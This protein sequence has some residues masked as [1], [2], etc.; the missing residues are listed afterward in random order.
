ML[1]VSTAMSSTVLSVKRHYPN[2]L[3]PSSLFF[4][5]VSALFIILFNFTTIGLALIYHF[6]VIMNR[7]TPKAESQFSNDARMNGIS[8]VL[9]L[10]KI[11]VPKFGTLGKQVRPALSII[12]VAQKFPGNCS[13]M[14]QI[15]CEAR[16]N[17]V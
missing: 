13:W 10:E 2:S 14:Q 4:S 15:S 16:C 1:P 3:E 12:C 7:Y 8:I 5:A 6:N 17:G 9:S 11:L